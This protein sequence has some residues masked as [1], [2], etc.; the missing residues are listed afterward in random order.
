MA[1]FLAVGGIVI[2]F[3]NI[4]DMLNYCKETNLEVCYDVCHSQLYCNKNKLS[5]IDQLKKIE[6]YVAH[7]H[8]SDAEGSEGEGLQFGERRSTI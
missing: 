5:V 8:L 7:Y 4:G 3:N 6:N 2:F 1:G